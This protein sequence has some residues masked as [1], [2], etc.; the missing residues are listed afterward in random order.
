M[1][2]LFFALFFPIFLQAQTFPTKRILSVKLAYASGKN[3]ETRK[4]ALT[5]Y[6]SGVRRFEQEFPNLKFTLSRAFPIKMKKDWNAPNYYID[7]QELYGTLSRIINS[8]ESYFVSKFT[9]EEIHIAMLSSPHII[10][11]GAANGLCR[12]RAFA[13]ASVFYVI[14]KKWKASAYPLNPIKIIFQHELGHALGAT[15]DDTTESVMHP[16][17]HGTSRVLKEGFVPQFS[18]KSKS[19]IKKC[20]GVI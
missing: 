16:A 7:G 6:R 19:E 10:A 2:Y 3:A 13:P 14:L 17:S 11:G 15:H 8:L 20:V 12:V 1:K 4:T 18:A 9:G 5:I